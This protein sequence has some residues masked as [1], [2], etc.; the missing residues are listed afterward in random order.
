MVT[1][2]RPTLDTTTLLTKVADVAPDGVIVNVVAPVLA[3]DVEPAAIRPFGINC[4]NSTLA[5]VVSE[6]I[7]PC[8]ETTCRMRSPEL[9]A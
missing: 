7:P 8:D 3:P 5:A 4:R 9:K 6:A 2:G 1:D